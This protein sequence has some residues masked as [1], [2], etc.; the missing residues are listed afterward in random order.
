LYQY[1]S[2]TE[3]IKAG[4]KN[5][6]SKDDYVRHSHIIPFAFH[7]YNRVHS[8]RVHLG[9]QITIEE[10]PNHA[11]CHGIPSVFTRSFLELISWYASAHS[12]IIV[13]KA[14]KEADPERA[15]SYSSTHE[16]HQG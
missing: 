3:A 5:A 11:K 7:P 16:G 4:E 13:A 8:R 10:G 14:G 9:T 6:P 15:L 1:C 12:S 2:L